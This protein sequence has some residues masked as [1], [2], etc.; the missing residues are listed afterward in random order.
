MESLCRTIDFLHISIDEG[1]DN[2][3]MFD[4]LP[5]AVTWGSIVCVQVVVMKENLPALEDKVA[6]CALVG[7]KCVVMPAVELNRTKSFFPDVD[8]FE[9]ECLRLKRKFPKTIISPDAYFRALRSPHG[10]STG[11]II[12]DCDGGLFYPCRTLESKPVNLVDTDLR[13]WL[14]SDE[15]RA[16][17]RAMAECDRNCGWYQYYAVNAFTSPIHVWNA[18]SPY[19]KNML[20]PAKG[21]KEKA[22]A[23]RS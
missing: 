16:S 13:D 8:E 14:R 7:A 18:V 10:C 4:L 20:A 2:L 1:H 6:R 9:R 23:T 15:A 19:L 17:R 5:Q 11:S 3:D 21:S 12:V 22:D